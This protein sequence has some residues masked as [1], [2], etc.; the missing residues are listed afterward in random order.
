MQATLPEVLQKLR[1][2]EVQLRKLGV[3]H[4][5]VFGSVARGA[6]GPESDIDILVELDERRPMGVFEYSR[7]RLYIGELLDGAGD[8]VNAKTLKPLI[9]DGILHD[10]VNAF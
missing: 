3:A 8:V 9:R 7:L 6:A 10:A 4:A 5:S 1:S 2:N